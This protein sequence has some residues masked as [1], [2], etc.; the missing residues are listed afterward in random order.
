MEIPVARAESAI[1]DSAVA[2]N[3]LEDSITVLAH[4]GF[5]RKEAG[6]RVE[7]AHHELVQSGRDPDE[8]RLLTRALVSSCLSL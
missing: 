1:A 5:F 4:L 3:R 2:G 8:K 6:A 7:R